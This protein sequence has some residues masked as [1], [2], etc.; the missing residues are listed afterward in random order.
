MEVAVDSYMNIATTIDF[1]VQ[2]SKQSRTQY[3]TYQRVLQI[4]S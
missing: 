4:V 3:Q 2:T 1:I